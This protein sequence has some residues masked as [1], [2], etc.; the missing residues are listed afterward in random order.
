MRHL[1]DEPVLDFEAMVEEL[2]EV[3]VGDRTL[4]DLLGLYYAD[5]QIEVSDRATELSAA[6]RVTPSPS[7][8][9]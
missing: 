1:R 9:S 4:V 8:R 2:R 7:S 3:M 6:Y 5:W